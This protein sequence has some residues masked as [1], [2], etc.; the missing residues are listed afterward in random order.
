[1]SRKRLW[2]VA[3]ATA[4]LLLIGA[5]FITWLRYKSLND[6]LARELDDRPFTARGIESIRRVVRQ[7]ASTR[8]KSKDGWT[9]PMAAAMVGDPSLLKQVLDGG[10]DP[11]AR[12]WD[13][14][15][16]LMWVMVSRNPQKVSTLLAAGA[17]PNA[18]DHIGRTPLMFAAEFEF[19]AAARILLNSGAV[20]GARNS[21]GHTALAYAAG[22]P[23]LVRLL[24]Q[25]G[26][27]E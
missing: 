4:L 15:T 20:T 7:G 14:T 10:G 16:A 17:D 23:G 3:S 24:K 25:H 9:V 1:M 12:A 19:T 2:E 27:R 21:N 8:T 22:H 13:G 5:V 11:N 26:A 18:K 6:T